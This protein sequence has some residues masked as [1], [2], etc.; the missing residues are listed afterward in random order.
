MFGK[1]IEYKKTRIS[2]F[3]Y[4]D[5][6]RVFE[7]V[8]ALTF[9]MICIILIITSKVNHQITNSITMSVVQVSMPISNVISM[10]LNMAIG[11]SVDLQE[12][13]NAKN[14]NSKLIKENEALRSLYIKSLNI[15]QEN[16]ELRD[17]LHYMGDRSTKFIATRLIAYS[18]QTFSRNVFI[19]AGSDQGVKE[20]DFVTG[21]NALIGRV[22]KVG[23]D[24]SLVLLITDVNSRV[25]IIVS[26]SRTK[27]ILAGNNSKLMEILYLEKDH[28]VKAGD[29][30]FTSGD[31]EA[32]PP[33]TLAGVV[34]KVD[35]NY[36]AVEM[37]E[38]VKNLNM[39]SVVNY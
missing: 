29:L 17:I 23:A 33:G 15:S 8:E 12:L 1:Q 9:L 10:P 19:G 30:V 11:F 7:K 3:S 26:G 14:K 34:S 36:A 21:S 27:G 16:S 4:H 39:V 20:D 37:V 38:N 31:G 5:I 24:K 28:Q 35:K 32:L 25:P 13:I 18:Y 2:F 22:K 6:R